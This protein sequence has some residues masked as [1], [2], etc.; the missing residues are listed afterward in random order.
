MIRLIDLLKESKIPKILYH[1]V[2]SE[3][4]R[5]F[6]LQNGIKADADSMVYLSEK[7]IGIPYKY[8]FAVTVPNP[9]KLHDWR[10][11]WDTANDKEYDADNPY[12]VYEGD[13]SKLY[14]K[15]V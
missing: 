15:L 14:V 5:D 7:P 13:I 12:Y 6:I 11:V 4:E 8:T 10:E 2:R 1:S 9:D 3:K